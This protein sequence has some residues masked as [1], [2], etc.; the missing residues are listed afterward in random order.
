MAL[1]SAKKIRLILAGKESVSRLVAQLAKTQEEEFRTE[2]VLMPVDCESVFEPATPSTPRAVGDGG[3]KRPG[4]ITTHE[5]GES[6]VAL[7]DTTRSGMRYRVP[8]GVPLPSAVDDRVRNVMK[9]L[10]SRLDRN[11]ISGFKSAAITL[12]RTMSFLP[13]GPKER[14]NTPLEPVA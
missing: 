3:P 5:T 9:A 7:L 14:P 2:A 1:L 4:S 8:D 12:A 10:G 13:P 6:G 11:D